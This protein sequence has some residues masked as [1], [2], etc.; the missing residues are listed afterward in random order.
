[1]KL[2]RESIGNIVTIDTTQLSRAEIEVT[3]RKQKPSE[4]SACFE[5]ILHI[6]N[7]PDLKDAILAFRIHLFTANPAK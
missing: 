1:M 7:I 3:Q 6:D 2:Q 4:M 5:R